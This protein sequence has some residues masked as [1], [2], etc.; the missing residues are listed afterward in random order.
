MWRL[1]LVAVCGAVLTSCA[2]QPS[3]DRVD[4]G[5]VTPWA[6]TAGAQRLFVAGSLG[7]SPAL[8]AIEPGRSELHFSSQPQEPYAE[9]ARLTAVTLV[10]DSIAAIGSTTGGAHGN[11]RWTIWDGTIASAT[12]TSRPQRFFTFGGHDAGPLLGTALV[13]GRLVV[14]GSRTITAGTRAALY[15]RS[16][17]T[18]SELPTPAELTSDASRELGFTGFAALGDRLAIVGDELGLVGGLDQRPALWVGIPG[19][20]WQQLR[21]PI[22][23]ELSGP[24]LTHATSIACV[25]T[26][27][28]WVAG[29][30]HG[31]AIVWQVELADSATPRVSQTSLLPG[32]AGEGADPIALLTIV[33]RRPVVAPNAAGSALQLGCANGWRE[34]PGPGPVRALAATT[35]R[36]YAISQDGLWSLAAPTC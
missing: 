35:D 26:E 28:C 16:A 17:T 8:V 19:G 20:P 7:A 32:A 6:M 27:L 5:G 2:Q 10:G 9:T 24:G 14:V 25:G 34:L 29:W 36:L 33:D 12:L 11:S 3:W 1:I 30:A 23:D 15:V 21:L 22:P 31:R 18:W 13:G 4:V